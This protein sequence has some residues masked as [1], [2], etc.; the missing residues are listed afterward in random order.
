M[1]KLV[2]KQLWKDRYKKHIFNRCS[3][4]FL[5]AEK[6]Y[7]HEEDCENWNHYKVNL[8]K[9]GKNFAEFKNY[10]NKGKISS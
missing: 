8:P 7:A 2:S 6:L 4:Y 5:S 10:N 9:P 1:P 3:H